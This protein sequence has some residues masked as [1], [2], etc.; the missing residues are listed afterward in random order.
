MAD[1][2]MYSSDEEERKIR[3]QSAE[4]VQKKRELI[5]RNTPR[6]SLISDAHIGIVEY[7]LEKDRQRRL[8]SWKSNESREPL[9][10][11]IRLLEAGIALITGESHQ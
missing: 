11:E 4:Q 9:M 2:E 6:Q 5:R 8:A 7:V 3:T 10:T 1:F